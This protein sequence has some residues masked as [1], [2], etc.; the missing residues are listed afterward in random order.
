[1]TGRHE[2]WEVKTKQGK[3]KNDRQIRRMGSQN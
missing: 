2:E 3:R 1:M